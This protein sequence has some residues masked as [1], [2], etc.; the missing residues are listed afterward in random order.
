M[1]HDGTN[2]GATIDA[3]EQLGFSQQEAENGEKFLED[4]E[5]LF[6]LLMAIISETTEL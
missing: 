6:T 2:V 5:Y 4:R 1:K 3:L